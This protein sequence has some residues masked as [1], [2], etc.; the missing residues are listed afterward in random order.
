MLR[1]T[2]HG[3]CWTIL[4]GPR[5]TQFDLELTMQTTKMGIKDTLSTLPVGSRNSSRSRHEL[6]SNYELS[7]SIR[8]SPNNKLKII[9]SPFVCPLNYVI[10]MEYKTIMQKCLLNNILSYMYYIED[11]PIG[12]NFKLQEEGK[13][14][15]YY[16]CQTLTYFTSSHKRMCLT[17][18]NKKV[19]KKGY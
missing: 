1:D 19:I 7:I 9:S 2:L 15:N 16:K 12:L 18:I 6:C 5:V 17:S 8:L 13:C 10:G 4:S 3:H 14:Y 11:T